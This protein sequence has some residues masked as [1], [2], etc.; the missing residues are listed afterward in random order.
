MR[1]RYIKVLNVFFYEQV[2]RSRVEL[3][4]TQEEMAHRLAMANRNYVDLDHGK[5]GCGGLTLAMYLVYVCADPQTFLMK[6][7]RALDDESNKAAYRA[8]AQADKELTQLQNKKLERYEAYRNGEISREDFLEIKEQITFQADEL[9]AKKEQLERDYQAL[10][11]AKQNE[12]ETQAEFSQAE[13]V[14][15]DY[16][17]GLHEHLYDAIE[18]VIVTTNEQIE[19]EWVFADIFTQ[20]EVCC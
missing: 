13:K 10:L 8:I 1:K 4:L 2:L 15:A 6:L 19:I 20:K 9:T 12:A 14:L 5:L 18:R 16:D 17:A 11:Q 7:R 3:G